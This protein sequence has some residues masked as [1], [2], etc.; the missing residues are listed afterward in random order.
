M[1]GQTNLYLEQKFFTVEVTNL[2]Q[3]QNRKHPKGSLENLVK[4]TK[5]S[6]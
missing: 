2:I 6:I 3:E 4:Y 5:E 1:L